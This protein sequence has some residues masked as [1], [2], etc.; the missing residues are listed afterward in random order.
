[1]KASNWRTSIKITEVISTEFA[2]RRTVLMLGVRDIE[3]RALPSQFLDVY[4]AVQLRKL[5]DVV[6]GIVAHRQRQF[7][8]EFPPNASA[9]ETGAECKFVSNYH[10]HLDQTQHILPKSACSDRSC[11]KGEA[12]ADHS[13]LQALS[14]ARERRS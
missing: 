11:K 2:V 9:I 4:L 7:S 13:T 12:L 3:K 5:S 14:Q 10:F 8:E 1:M 6:F